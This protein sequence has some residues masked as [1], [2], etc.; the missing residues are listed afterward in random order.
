MKYFNK[1]K[2]LIFSF[3]KKGLSS[4]E[5]ALAIAV[6]NFVGFIPVFGTHTITAIGLSYLLR[7]N[8]LIVILGTQISNP[9]SFPFQIFISAEVGN[10]ILKGRFLDIEFSK[11]M[12]FLNHYILPICVGSLV[13][14]VIVACLSYF[15]IKTFLNRRRARA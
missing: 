8:A 5:I 2:A 4:A 13:L 7:L 11:D 14:G 9:I 12:N 1:L 3:S 15:L 6:G 10:L